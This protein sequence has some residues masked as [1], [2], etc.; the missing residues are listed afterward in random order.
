MSPFTI[1][2]KVLILL[3][4]LASARS[5]A[6]ERCDGII[7]NKIN[8][9]EIVLKSGINSPYQ[10]AI[11]YDTGYLF[12]SY[13]ANDDEVF[14]SAYINLKTNNF[15]II[16]GVSGGFANAVDSRKHNVYIGGRDGLYKFDFDSKSAKHIDGTDDNIWQLFYKDELYY[17]R[18]PDEAVY[19]YKEGRCER[20]PELQDTK[21]MLVALDNYKN[22][23]F[24]NSSGMYMHKKSNGQRGFIGDFNANGFA[25]DINGNLFFSTPDGVYFINVEKKEVERI[26]AIG[27][28]YGV[29]IGGDGSI[30]YA[31][32][33]AIIR[34]NPTETFCIV[35]EFKS[36]FLI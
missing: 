16:P 31:S 25:T 1:N 33:N 34:L 6:T 12:F 22:F 11:D 18:Y 24:T 2:M 17:S 9:E 29:A 27:N 4:I 21:A 28:A 30:I 23:Y 5:R 19:M 15:G 10:L 13:S 32:Q 8:H 3:S 26:A 36:P 14:K 20:V 35:D 7:V